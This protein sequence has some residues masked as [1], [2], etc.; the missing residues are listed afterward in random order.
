MVARPGRATGTGVNTEPHATVTALEPSVVFGTVVHT[1]F[2]PVRHHFTYPV[3]CLRLPL[4]RLKQLRVPLLGVDRANVF[5]VLAKDHGNRDGS[6]LGNWARQVLKAYQLDTAADGEIVL[7]TFPRMFGH[8]FNP[9]SFLF[10]HDREGQLRAVIAEVNN[11]FGERH[12]Y[13]VARPDK[14]PLAPGEHLPV[15]KIFHVSPFCE[16]AGEYHF[17][18]AVRDGHSRVT[19]EYRQDDQRVLFTAIHGPMTPLDGRALRQWLWRFPAMTLGVVC[20]IH[21]Q[22]W[23]LWRKRVKFFSKPLPPTEEISS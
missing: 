5:S 9:V 15:R 18:F 3:A 14:N 7:Q 17:Q 6:D 19:I 2:T 23:R 4:S 8:V 11:T 22:A 13:V 20:R 10:C 21:L 16:V 12:G 1:R